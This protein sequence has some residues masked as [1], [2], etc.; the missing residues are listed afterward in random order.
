MNEATKPPEPNEEVFPPLAD[1]PSMPTI[2]DAATSTEVKEIATPSV[3]TEGTTIPEV[4]PAK[5]PWAEGEPPTPPEP[6]GVPVVVVVLIFVVAAAA[7]LFLV[8]HT[9]SLQAKINQVTL[10]SK[11]VKAQADL[12]QT[13]LDQLSL[14]TKAQSTG[15]LIVSAVYGSGGAFKDVT[16]RVNT[17]LHQPDAEFYAKPEWLHDDPAPGWNKELVICYKIQG[18][19][20]IFMTGEGGKVSVAA[21]LDEAKK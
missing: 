6:A 20:H 19:R 10:E 2:D 21:L 18:Q 9:R 7:I 11:Q 13:Q 14:T 12:L 1:D 15:L 3:S 16:D 4:A 5:D 17:L 8:S